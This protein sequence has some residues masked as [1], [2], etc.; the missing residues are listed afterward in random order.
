MEKIQ[1]TIL[2][3][4]LGQIYAKKYEKTLLMH[5]KQTISF[6]SSQ[7]FCIFAPTTA[8]SAIQYLGVHMKFFYHQIYKENFS[9]PYALVGSSISGISAAM[10]LSAELIFQNGSVNPNR[11][12][13]TIS[14]DFCNVKIKQGLSVNKKI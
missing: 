12:L 7:C 3:A 8:K 6:F 2:F 9:F 4:P 10:L 11:S 13:L 1:H 5:L 14:A